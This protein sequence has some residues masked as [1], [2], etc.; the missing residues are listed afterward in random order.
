MTCPRLTPGIHYAPRGRWAVGLTQ[1]I[2]YGLG[3]D[4][5]AI[6]EFYSDKTLLATHESGW[7]TISGNYACDGY[8]PVLHFRGRFIRLTPTPCCGMFPA[9]QH[10]LQRQFVGVEG[11]PWTREQTDRDFYDAM[12]AGRVHRHLAGTFYGTVAGP[13]GNVFIRLT[14]RVDPTLRIVRTEY[15]L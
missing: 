2:G 14:R 8:S 1:P 13:A 3:R 15:P 10:D 11:C 7:M 12:I 5:G 9:I 4:L 6:Y